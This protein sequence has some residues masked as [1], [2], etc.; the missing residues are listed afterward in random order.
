MHHLCKMSVRAIS[1]G[2]GPFEVGKADVSHFF[3]HRLFP[4]TVFDFYS[5]IFQ[6]FKQEIFSNFV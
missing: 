3:Q 2:N 4:S 6:S 1:I 5:R